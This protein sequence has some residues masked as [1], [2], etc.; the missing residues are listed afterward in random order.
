MFKPISSPVKRNI[1]SFFKT[2]PV[3]KDRYFWVANNADFE[4]TTTFEAIKQLFDVPELTQNMRNT[5]NISKAAGETVNSWTN[6]PDGP[7]A[8][9]LD[10]NR[11]GSTKLD[12]ILSDAF[13]AAQTN[14]KNLLVLPLVDD[15]GSC[16]EICQK[17]A[18]SK[19]SDAYLYGTSVDPGATTIP[20]MTDK[21]NDNIVRKKV[22]V[23]SS[24][25]FAQGSEFKTVIAF[26]PEGKLANKKITTGSTNGKF[27]LSKA[28]ML[29]RAVTN[30]V[31]ISVA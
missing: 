26:I 1:V 10:W 24:M 17:E 15:L 27:Y 4:V 29:L 21:E 22:T 11:N 12:E 13:E 8:T 18:R 20:E 3:P 25:Y 31:V 30:L 9:T 23:V 5:T 7:R 19:K 14:F 28:N 6:Y 16:F 2:K